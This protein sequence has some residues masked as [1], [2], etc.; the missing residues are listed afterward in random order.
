MMLLP[1]AA[2]TA[3]KVPPRSPTQTTPSSHGGRRFLDALL[4]MVFPAQLSGFEIERDEIRG[5]RADINGAIRDSRGR[6]DR[7]A[8]IVGPKQFQ[9]CG[10][11]RGGNAG[12]LRI[13]AKLRPRVALTGV[14]APALSAGATRR[15]R[16]NLRRV[17]QLVGGELDLVS[18][19]I[20]EVDRMSD[21][22]IFESERNAAPA[23]FGLRAQKVG[24]IHLKRQMAHDGAVRDA[25]ARG[26]GSQS[27]QGRA[28][29]R[30]RPRT[31]W[32]ARSPQTS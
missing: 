12:Q 9:C 16:R 19:G 22:M 25:R 29:L 8:G 10:K 18:I 5:L 2:F 6:F 20:V 23:Q 3:C 1:S 15:I 4:D 30:F 27:R 28:R 11:G 21:L 14:S 24:A 13:A 17:I 26:L 31:S 7:V 32:P